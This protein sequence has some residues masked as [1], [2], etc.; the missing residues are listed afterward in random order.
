MLT[1]IMKWV[2]IATLLLALIWRASEAYQLVRDCVVC[3]GALLVV[4]QAGRAGRYFWAAGF[5]A[6]AVLFNPVVPVVVSHKMFLGLGW[7]S[8]GAFLISLAILRTQPILSMPSIT[9]RTP[10]SESL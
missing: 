7:V 4:W 1:K 9:N 10:E 5:L 8:L 6:I 2:S 3:L